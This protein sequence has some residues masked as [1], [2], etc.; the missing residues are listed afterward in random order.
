[1]LRKGVLVAV[2]GTFLQEKIS[3]LEKPSWILYFLKQKQQVMWRT[4][5]WEPAGSGYQVQRSPRWK[6]GIILSPGGSVVLLSFLASCKEAECP[7]GMFC[8]GDDAACCT[9]LQ[10]QDDIVFPRLYCGKMERKY[11]SSFLPSHGEK[12]Q[13]N[14]STH[15]KHSSACSSF[16]NIK[17][18]SSPAKETIQ[19]E[20]WAAFRAFTRVM[21][22]TFA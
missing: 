4:C 9:V 21:S 12:R 16:K 22:A 5:L 7:S 14:Q 18:S 15:C 8:A 1:M 2:V 20:T 6:G 19:E 10:T 3:V 11:Q 17:K 13:E